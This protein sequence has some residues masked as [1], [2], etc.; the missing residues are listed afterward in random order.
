MCAIRERPVSRVFI[1]INDLSKR[2]RK[3]TELARDVG[4]E[5]QRLRFFDRR[6]EEDTR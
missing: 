3:E 5:H 6:L 1:K 4:T 2:G